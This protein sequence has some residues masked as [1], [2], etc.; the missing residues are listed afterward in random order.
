ML[1]DSRFDNGL[2]DLGEA[3]VCSLF[4]HSSPSST[5]LGTILPLSFVTGGPRSEKLFLE[6]RRTRET[7]RR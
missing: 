1:K 4:T 5:K 6:V 3:G 2:H 7:G